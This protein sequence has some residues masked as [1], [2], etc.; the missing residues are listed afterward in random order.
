MAELRTH[1]AMIAVARGI[2]ISHDA[3]RIPRNRLCRV[4][5]GRRMVVTPVVRGRREYFI[6]LHGLAMLAV[7]YTQLRIVDEPA[8]WLWAIE[9]ART[10]MP[11]SVGMLIE[12][13]VFGA[14]MDA[15]HESLDAAASALDGGENSSLA[16]LMEHLREPSD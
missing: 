10:P 12:N 5:P 13:S 4:H 15:G 14:V 11:P 6:A 9:H 8:C 16:R 7:D 2:T 1:L 3:Q